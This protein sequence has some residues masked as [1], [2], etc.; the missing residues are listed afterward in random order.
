MKNMSLSDI[1]QRNIDIVQRTAVCA[2]F[3][4]GQLF[5][6]YVLSYSGVLVPYLIYSSGVYTC[7]GRI[8]IAVSSSIA[9]MP[10]LSSCCLIAFD[11]GT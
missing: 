11:I 2:R 3:R 4:C 7:S 6:V 9:L 10:S 8:F 5:V 1:Q